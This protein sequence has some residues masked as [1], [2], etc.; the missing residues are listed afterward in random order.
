MHPAP[1]LFERFRLS[2]AKRADG[3]GALNVVAILT[4]VAT[5][6]VSVALLKLIGVV[7]TWGF[8]SN[9]SIATTL[10]VPI[11]G[12]ALVSLVLWL[13]PGSGGPGTSETLNA[14][15]RNTRLPAH[16]IVGK[17]VASAIAI[18]T[19]A[20]GGREGPSVQIGATIGQVFSRFVAM[21]TEQTRT[22]MAAG[23]AAGIS[24]A[25]N[26]P[27][28]GMIFA[29][30]VIIGGFAVRSLQAV[31]VA[32]V[33]AS[34]VAQ[35]LLGN[36]VH[37]AVHGEYALNHPLELIGYLLLGLGAAMIA[38]ALMLAR[39]HSATFLKLDHVPTVF[40]PIIAGAVIGIFALG[41]PEVVGMGDHLPA[42][43]NLSPSIGTSPL[44]TFIQGGP[45]TGIAGI[46]LVGVLIIAKIM[47]SGV[48][49]NLGQPVGTLAPCLFIGAA[50]GTM[51]AQIFGIILDTE[52][53]SPGAFAVVGMAA[54]LGAS[55]KAP[56]TAILLIFELTGAYN[57]VVPMMLA[58]GVSVFLAD[59][60]WNHS[61]F[62]W[63]LYETGERKLAP[64]TQDVLQCV[65]VEEIMSGTPHTVSPDMTVA[66]LK[67]LFAD[68]MINSAPV[69]QDGTL[70]GIVSGSDIRDHADLIARSG[71]D[72]TYVDDIATQRVTTVTTAD[73]AWTAMRRMSLLNVG[74]L[75]VVDPTDRT[76][77]I[78]LVSRADLVRAYQHGLVRSLSDQ[79]AREQ[80]R[81]RNLGG[82]SF[83]EAVVHQDSVVANRT[84]ATISWP[85]QTVLVSIQRDGDVTMPNGN[86]T[87]LPGDTVVYVAPTASADAV[88]DLIA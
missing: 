79:Q 50:W 10:L 66:E 65:G 6:L 24:A 74:R 73:M 86:T 35:M 62:T 80:S 4:G 32:S 46:L 48:S 44:L 11:I 22:M 30:E 21:D 59:R 85:V 84:V 3:D 33:V 61:M 12:G 18:G 63:A 47:A 38:R 83:R 58:T 68:K 39:Y 28:A 64:E 14:V 2:I 54:V 88:E 40:K 43:A 36:P 13:S 15:A 8:G 9:P 37:Y 23:A 67:T 69:V 75:P 72:Q 52:S 7:H 27:I 70:L 56:M 17:T 71:I 76:K 82:T 49:I 51:S 60:L 77:L 29:M 1:S 26:A 19:G 31:V 34:V 78:G 57:L 81:L 55:M 5:A 25:F 42:L 16:T 45:T 20:S 41:M 87:L 53:V